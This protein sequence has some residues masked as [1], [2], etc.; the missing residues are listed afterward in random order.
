MNKIYMKQVD[1]V[2]T[3]DVLLSVKQWIDI[4]K[5]STITQEHYLK[6]LVDWYHEPNHEQSSTHMTNKYFPNYDKSPYNGYV[7]AYANSIMYKYAFSIVWDE[8]PEKEE[9]TFYPVLFDGYYYYDEK[10]QKNLFCWRLKK[11]AVEALKIS[12]YCN[13]FKEIDQILLDLELNSQLL[14]EP[15]GDG[16]KEYDDKR[17][18]KL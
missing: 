16:R 10:D 12:N 4:L 8:K 7:R 17:V 14:N 3:C 1:G 5:D 13:Y 18:K 9:Y 11:E 2:Y 6:M 15:I